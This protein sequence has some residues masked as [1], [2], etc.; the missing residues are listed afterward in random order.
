M[1][2]NGHVLARPLSAETLAP[3]L[4]KASSDDQLVSLWL[5]GRALHTQRAYAADAERF[6]AYVGPLVTVSL[7]TCKA[8]ADSL[9]GLS[10][11]SRARTLAAI[12]SL[13]SFGQ[14]IGYPSFNVGAAVKLLARKNTLAERILQEPDVQ[15]M[16]ALEPGRRNYALLLLLYAAGLRVSEIAALKWHDLQ[17]RGDASQVNIFGK[18]SKTRVVLLPRSVW[19]ELLALRGGASVD[20]PLFTSRKDGGHLGPPAIWHIVLKAAQRAGLELAKYMNHR[21]SNTRCASDQVL[22]APARARPVGCAGG[23]GRR[24]YDRVTRLGEI[25]AVPAANRLTP[26]RGILASRSRSIWLCPLRAHGV[27]IVWCD[28]LTRSHRHDHQG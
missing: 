20:A 16:L 8:F 27:A 21:M 14:R 19:E 22:S 11:S 5:H 4:R 2:T 13:L 1:N 24:R 6:G 23:S 15:R 25:I 26:H 17:P 18:G 9:E 10:P 7:G 3:M 12:K 28:D